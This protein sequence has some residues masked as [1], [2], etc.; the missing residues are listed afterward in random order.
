MEKFNEDRRD[1]DTNRFLR[2]LIKHEKRVYAFILSLVSNS[3]D[4]D[5]IMQEVTTVMWKKFPNYKETMNFRSWAMTIAKY[6]VLSF[7]KKNKNR[8]VRF[9]SDLLDLIEQDYCSREPVDEQ[10]ELLELCIKELKTQDRDIIRLRYEDNLTL[11]SIG[12]K[13]SKSARAAHYALA[14]IH[15]L[16]MNCVNRKKA[17]NDL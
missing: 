2:L 17:R 7:Y 15:K 12:A 10:S 14:R 5:D 13:I 3:N 4:A 1:E 6:Q 9:S 16:L 11:K 8:K